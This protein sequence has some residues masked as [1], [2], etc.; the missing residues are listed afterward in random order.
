MLN[1]CTTCIS[2][3]IESYNTQ[4][5]RHNEHTHFCRNFRKWGGDQR[6]FGSFPKIHPFWYRAPSQ[7]ISSIYSIYQIRQTWIEQTSNFYFI[8]CGNCS[9]II[10]WSC[11][12]CSCLSQPLP[13]PRQSPESLHWSFEQNKIRPS[14]EIKEGQ[15]NKETQISDLVLVFEV[16]IRISHLLLGQLEG[17]QGCIRATIDARRFAW[18]QAKILKGNIK[19]KKN[20]RSIACSANIKQH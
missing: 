15:P 16:V 5:S 2:W 10:L 17:A 3:E 18:K 4:Q 13:C 1:C 6:P 8:K 19:T 12:S 7:K 14:N 9:F 20:S 11:I